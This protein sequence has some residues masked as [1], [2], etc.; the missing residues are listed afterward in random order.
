MS[1]KFIFAYANEGERWS[2]YC[3]TSG[4]SHSPMTASWGLPTAHQK[5]ING[6]MKELRKAD[7]R[8]K[9]NNLMC[10]ILH[11]LG[12]DQVGG[13]IGIV[14][15]DALVENTIVLQGILRKGEEHDEIH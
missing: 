3:I 7:D 2:V 5:V 13:D 11:S 14:I 6:Y 10:A 9:V 15:E 1:N 4:G 8:F 12:W